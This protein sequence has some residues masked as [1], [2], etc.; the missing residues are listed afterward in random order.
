MKK[1]GLLITSALIGVG[2]LAGDAVA[3]LQQVTAVGTLNTTDFFPLVSQ[4]ASASVTSFASVKQLLQ[5]VLGGGVSHASKP[6]LTGCVTTGGTIVG[7]DENFILT[8]GTT[9]TTSCT[10]T[11]STAYAS[12][13]VCT[14]SSQTAYATTTP[15]YTVSTSAVVITQASLSQEVYNVICVAQPGG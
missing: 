14:V 4:G 15:S 13:P 1:R 9:A 11:F 5:Y 12:T 10:A 6:T 3:Q 7:T 2:A 8:G